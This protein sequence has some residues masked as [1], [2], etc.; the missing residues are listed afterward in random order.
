[1]LVNHVKE[2]LKSVHTKALYSQLF[3]ELLAHCTNQ[4]SLLT[5]KYLTS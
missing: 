4:L 3:P 1:M 2:F 5:K